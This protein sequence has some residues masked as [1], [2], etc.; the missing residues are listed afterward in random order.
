MDFQHLG[1][2]SPQ[3]LCLIHDTECYAPVR[4]VLAFNLSLL[5]LLG[6]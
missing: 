1:L 2:A 5:L 3:V 6:L 4:C